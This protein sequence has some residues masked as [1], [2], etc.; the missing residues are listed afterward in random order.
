MEMTPRGVYEHQKTLA[1]GETETIVLPQAGTATLAVYALGAGVSATVS[2]STSPAAAV[3]A[4][5]ALWHPAPGF[6]V[7][8]VVTNASAMQPID[9]PLTAVRVVAA[10]GAVTVEFQ[11]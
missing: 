1:D 9:G 7:A 10:A 2:L 4:G 8:G 3:K 5:T 6:G 11:Q